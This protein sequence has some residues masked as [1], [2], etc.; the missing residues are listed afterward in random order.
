MR[1]SFPH[2]LQLS[3]V[4][5]GGHAG[6]GLKQLEIDDALEIPP[7]RQHLL[8]WVEVTFWLR[9]WLL[10]ATD[11]QPLAAVVHVKHPLFV[12]SDYLLQ[13]VLAMETRQ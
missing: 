6:I 11:L 10:V 13:E 9:F 5:G 7:N 4:E 2:L 3:T 8:F 12:S 1:Q